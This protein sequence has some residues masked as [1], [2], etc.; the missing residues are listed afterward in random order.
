MRRKQRAILVAGLVASVFTQLPRA[1]APQ[2][3][4]PSGVPA[5][6]D[7][8]I[9]WNARA[10]E[11]ATKACIAPLDDPFHESRM[12]AMMHIAIHDA[13]NA[14]DRRFQ[15]HA[16]DKRVEP[17][18]LPEAAAAAAARDVMVPL[19]G[20]LPHELPFITQACIDAAVAGVEAAYTAALAALPR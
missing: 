11:A 19:L 3:R 18:A 6:G 13:L 12:Y 2:N 4:T 20:Q 9:L 15:P 8:V 7:A 17:G 14:I 5:G 10:G 1:A 16:F